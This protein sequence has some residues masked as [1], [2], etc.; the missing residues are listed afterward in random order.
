MH[1]NADF[2]IHFIVLQINWVQKDLV[3]K[4]QLCGANI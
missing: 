4:Q 1:Q 3:V 2:K